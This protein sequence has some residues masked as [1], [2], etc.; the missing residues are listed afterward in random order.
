MKMYTSHRFKK[1]YAE[2]IHCDRA[3]ALGVRRQASIKLKSQ[4][5]LKVTEP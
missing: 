2:Q 5:L 1:R 3:K 4:E